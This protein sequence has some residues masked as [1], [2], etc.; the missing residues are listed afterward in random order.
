MKTTG[1]ALAVVSIALAIGAGVVSCSNDTL[2][3]G[4]QGLT[5][6]FV[7]NPSG[8]GRFNRGSFD[9][10]SIRIRPSDPATAS[11]Y[12]NT[13]LSLRFLSFTADMTQ[14]ATTFYSNVALS[15]GTYDVRQIVLGS[16]QLVDTGTPPGGPNCID[17][18]AAIPSGPATGQVPQIFTYDNPASLTFTVHPGQ[19]VLKITADIP[20]II[21]SYESAFTCV[22]DCGSGTPCLTQFDEAAF[23]AAFLTHITLQ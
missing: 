9:I 8:S 5:V 21:S 18:I 2:D 1:R 10:R 13:N 19:T 16:P 22:S 4:T 12:G 15:A 3:S 17:G 20:A 6:N 23:T 14:S 7:P 11:A